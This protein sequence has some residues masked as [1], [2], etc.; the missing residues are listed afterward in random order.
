MADK[1]VSV[2]ENFDFP[3]PVAAR[4]AAVTAASVESN[5]RVD[6]PAVQSYLLAEAMRKLRTGAGAKFVI[7]GDSTTYGHDVSSADI[8]GPPTGTLPN[9]T[10]HSATRS[11]S[12]Y[13]DVFKRALTEVYAGTIVVENQG[14]SGDYTRQGY[15]RWLTNAGADV[16]I[17][18]YGINDST[19]PNIPA[20]IRGNI[21]EYVRW[22]EAMIIRDLQWGSAV[23]LMTPLRQRG[24]F[25]N[26]TIDAYRSALESLATKYGIPIIDGELLLMNAPRDAWSDNTHFTTKGNQIIGSR[27]AA[28]FTGGGLQRRKV[29]T[30][31]SKLL[32]R[33]TLDNVVHRGSQIRNNA[34]F[35]TPHDEVDGQG[36]VILVDNGN[37]SH[38]S[39][40]ADTQDLV[41]FPVFF[42]QAS[43]GEEGA[44]LSFTLDHGAEQGESSLKKS[45]NVSAPNGARYAPP[46]TV[47]TPPLTTGEINQFDPAAPTIHHVRISTPGWHTVTVTA[48]R[49][50]TGPIYFHG[51]EVMSWREMQAL[52][53]AAGVQPLLP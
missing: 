28:A 1:L 16:T 40:Y 5:P 13:P 22:H 30:P 52:R 34:S 35:G 29:I 41:L 21:A 7:R 48:R 42:V 8:V 2:D 51:W 36:S 12:P 17:I 11:P 50:S 39:F 15:Q 14:F 9:G 37:K 47:M 4:Q 53:R 38:W 3:A 23:V 18:S 45:L 46:A 32:I 25:A 31:G 43:A 44:Y 10:K 26:V 33:T 6:G 19:S 20:E 27:L 49:T 24:A